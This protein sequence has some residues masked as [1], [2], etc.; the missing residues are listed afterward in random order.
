[1]TKEPIPKD[2]VDIAKA[3]DADPERVYAEIQRSRN[4]RHQERLKKASG[5]KSYTMAHM[6]AAMAALEREGHVRPTVA[7]VQERMRANGYE[8]LLGGSGNILGPL[9]N[10]L[11]IPERKEP[12]KVIREKRPMRITLTRYGHA[13]AKAHADAFLDWDK[14]QRG[15]R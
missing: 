8:P 5:G 1:M 7:Q 12:V 2:V 13:W 3:Y 10:M 15:E 9:Q 4:V 11:G 6:L 14:A